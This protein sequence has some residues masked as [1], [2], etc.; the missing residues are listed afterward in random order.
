MN[1]V[2]IIFIAGIIETYLFAGWTIAANKS[3][4][5]LSSGLMLT[6]M[7]IYLFI[8]DT[9]FKDVNSKLLIITYAIACAVGNFIRVKR[10]KHENHKK[11]Y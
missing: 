11:L 10:E 9:A 4:P 8:L 5:I 1:K 7:V 3:K 2:L 6:Y